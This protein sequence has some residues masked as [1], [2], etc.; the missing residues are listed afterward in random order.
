MTKLLVFGSEEAQEKDKITIAV[1][2]TYDQET[3]S[4]NEMFHNNG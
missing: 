1:N 3:P 2:Q 4:R